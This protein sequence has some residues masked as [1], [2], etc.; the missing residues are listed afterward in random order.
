MCKISV[1]MPVYNSKEYISTAVESVLNQSFTDFELLLIDDGSADGSE[2]LCDEF[3]NKDSRVKV[4][5][6]EN[7]G[8]CSA[9]NFGLNNS[10]GEYISF[11]DNDDIYQ[12]NFL[13][14]AYM[15]ITNESADFL[16]CGYE[17]QYCVDDIIKKT[18]FYIPKKNITL[19][20][21]NLA[22]NY[23][24]LKSKEILDPVW[25]GLYKKSFLY[26]YKIKFNESVKGG[27]DDQL[28]NI[29]LLKH[30]TKA[31][32]INASYYV[33]IQR[34]NHSTSMKFVEN[35]NAE[36]WETFE[37]ERV[38]LEAVCPEFFETQEWDYRVVEYIFRGLNTSLNK[39]ASAEKSIKQQL[40][41]Y[42][43]LLSA[44][45]SKGYLKNDLFAAELKTNK[46]RA[47]LLLLMILHMD[48]SSFLLSK[49][50][51]RMRGV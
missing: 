45:R 29:E 38:M 42:K 26:K 11:I 1:I 23:Y 15:A 21:N 28:F 49:I 43:D 18:I 5:H 13:E 7:G 22:A 37:Q 51:L 46:R 44:F 3:A 10:S 36:R 34:N 32:I 39:L 6:K 2:K 31:A 20:K 30:F 8:I 19:T 16:K 14:T 27:I 17:H 47:F 50:Y 24:C 33:W 41:D 35:R 40:K 9:R 4:F 12:K 25:N 48:T